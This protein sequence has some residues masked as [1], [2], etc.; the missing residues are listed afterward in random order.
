MLCRGTC[1]L[2][3]LIWRLT[4]NLGASFLPVLLPQKLK[5]YLQ[6]DMMNL[7]FSK[8]GKLAS[9]EVICTNVCKEGGACLTPTCDDIC[10][11]LSAAG[12]AVS[13]NE[14]IIPWGSARQNGPGMATR[15]HTKSRHRRHFFTRPGSAWSFKRC[16]R[17]VAS[18]PRC[19]PIGTTP[20]G[21]RRRRDL[22]PRMWG[23]RPGV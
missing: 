1:L 22:W 9:G 16:A 8:Q 19:A 14:C 12:D 3:G 21:R 20:T 15:I 17:S 6:V 7:C 2:F 11:I 5:L 10:S 4:G 18:P 23:P 13:N